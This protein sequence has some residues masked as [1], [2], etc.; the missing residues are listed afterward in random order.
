[1]KRRVKNVVAPRGPLRPAPQ[2]IVGDTWVYRGRQIDLYEDARGMW[3]AQW[4]DLP[5]T[6]PVPGSATCGQSLAP[7]PSPQGALQIARFH[8]DLAERIRERGLPHEGGT[9][10]VLVDAF[11]AVKEAV[12]WIADVE[13][14]T[15]DRQN[16]ARR[17]E[18]QRRRGD[19]N[20][21]RF[22]ELPLAERV[23][24]ID[25]VLALAST[26]GGR[27]PAWNPDVPGP[28]RRVFTELVAGDVCVAK[29]MLGAK[30]I[31]RLTA[32]RID[33][34]GMSPP[35]RRAL[36][37][38]GRARGTATLQPW[39]VVRVEVKAPFRNDAVGLELYIAAAR[40][41]SPHAGALVAMSCENGPG[42]TSRDAIRVWQS[43]RLRDALHVHGS[44]RSGYVAALRTTGPR[45]ELLQW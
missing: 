11:Y 29:A 40:A 15:P 41:I 38:V 36:A 18:E 21:K 5:Q 37:E 32:E 3:E 30:E 35:C 6:P 1:M 28:Q 12:N 22:M 44:A 39:V 17:V 45:G 31:G 2:H 4:E 19:H 8:I 9:A 25:E 34:T 14:R 26:H 13:Q 20:A 16:V 24:L 33:M 27:Y 10:D 23:E 43:E 42:W 7:S